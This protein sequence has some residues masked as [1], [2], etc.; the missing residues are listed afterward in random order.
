MRLR[1]TSTPWA[2][3]A[4]SADLLAGAAEAASPAQPSR[5]WLPANSTFCVDR[6]DSAEVAVRRFVLQP[7]LQ[8]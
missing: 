1:I 8:S 2:N 7:Q 5:P 4:S 3:G 6:T